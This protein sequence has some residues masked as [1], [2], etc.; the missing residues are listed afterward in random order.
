MF[1]L[2][3]FRSFQSFVVLVVSVVSVVSVEYSNM[4][5]RPNSGQLTQGHHCD[6]ESHAGFS[7]KILFR[8]LAVLEDEVAGGGGPNAELVFFLSQFQS[9]RW[10]GDEKG[11]N[12]FV[13]RGF[14]RRR[15]NDRRI[16][17]VT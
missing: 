6:F 8:N 3:S 2:F 13:L 15:E 10:F 16:C 12:P 14:V 5:P 9:L 7:E 1:H 4:N 17:L 11:G